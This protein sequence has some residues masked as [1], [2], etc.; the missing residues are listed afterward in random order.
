M[1]LSLL[2]A[3]TSPDPEA[4]QGEHRFTYS[5]LPHAGGWETETAAEAY[6]LNDPVIGYRCSVNGERLSV[7]GVQLPMDSEKPITD[8]RSPI[9]VHHSLLTVSAPNIIIETVK[10]AEDGNGLIVRFYD[11]LLYT[12]RCV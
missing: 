12:S 8:Y 7:I 1:R 3:P 9:T 10:R 2:R 4:D 6:R 5:L 11:C